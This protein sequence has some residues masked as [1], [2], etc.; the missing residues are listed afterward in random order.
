MT[1]YPNDVRDMADCVVEAAREHPVP[2]ALAGLGLGYLLY[3]T[4]TRSR[5]SDLRQSEFSD[6][7]DPLADGPA[8]DMDDYREPHPSRR[9]ARETVDA[10]RS[11]GARAGEAATDFGHRAYVRAESA[12]RYAKRTFAETVD[13][14]PLVL[15]AIGLAIGAA[16][17]AA[18]P[19]T[20][21]ERAWLGDAASEVRERGQAYAREQWERG[22]RV[23]EKATAAA[24]AEAK[25]QGLT[26]DDLADKAE[27]VAE[28]GTDAGQSELNR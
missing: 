25:R 27:Q 16:V 14:R 11:A 15:A 1:D 18:L 13:E 19:R 8:Y 24:K 28:A 23:V 26:P 7:I 9:R 4:L 21:Q 22:E 12:G 5:N 3:A 10:V 6:Y 17:G 20:R 2:V